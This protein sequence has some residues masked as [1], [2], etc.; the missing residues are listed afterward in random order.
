MSVE[1][2]ARAHRADHRYRAIR[3][4]KQGS[5]RDAIGTLTPGYDAFILTFGQF[6]LI[7]VLSTLLEQTGPADVIISTWTAGIRD[8]AKAA[9]LVETS[10]IRSLRF[11]VDR[12]F[13]T[14]Q[15]EYCRAMRRAFG[16]G[17]IRTCRTHA[18]FMVVHN[19]RWHLAIR[20]SM[21]L[22]ENEQMENLE[23]SDDPAL[24]AFLTQ[25]ADDVYSEQGPGLFDGELP[26]LASVPNVRV[27]GTVSAGRVAMDLTKPSVGPWRGT[28]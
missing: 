14:R 5:A 27:A 23:I 19:E 10:A 11:L 20:T 6:S 8:T 18:K 1:Q 28:P 24:C 7:D 21:N 25:V 4:A 2:Q 16:D 26:E 15:P 12:S 3:A 13:L 22:N 9:W 17:C